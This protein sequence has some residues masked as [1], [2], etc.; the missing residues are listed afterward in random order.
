MRKKLVE[1][2]APPKHRRKG[3]W[4]IVQ[5]TEGIIV[6][7]IFQDGILKSR[8]C[9]DTAG[10]DYATWFPEGKW[11]RRKIEWSYD[12]E[13]EWQCCYYDKSR[14]K[15]FRVSDTDRKLLLD[16]FPCPKAFYDRTDIFGIIGYTEYKW[17]AERREK[18][19]ERR[20]EKVDALMAKMPPLPDGLEDWFYS[21]AVGEEFALK[22]S[23]TGQFVCTVCRNEAPR[24]AYRRDDGGPAKNND[25]AA[26]PQCGSRIR[27]KTRMRNVYADGDFLLMQPVDSTMSVIRLF[28][29]WSRA[30][31]NKKD[32]C[33]HEKARVLAG[34]DKNAV[35]GKNVY[36]WQGYGRFDN[37][38]NPRQ[39]RLSNKQ[40]LYPEGIGQALDGTAAERWSGLLKEFVAAGMKLSYSHLI[41]CRERDALPLMEMLFRG[42]F[43]R[44]LSEESGH[45]WSTG[46]Y[47][48]TLNIKGNSISDV[49]RISE[50]QLINRLRDKNGGGLMLEWLLW[51]ERNKKKLSDRV[52]AWLEENSLRPADMEWIKQRFSPEQAVNYLERQRH[53]QYRGRCIREVIGQ[54]RDY[55]DMCRRLKKDTSDEMVYR[56]R[57]LKRRHD[58]AV[59]ELALR[60][61]EIKA[62]EYSEK[63]PEAEKVLE[64]IAGK[65]E[66]SN[67]K[68]MIVV[69][70]KNIDIVKEGRTL[71]HCAG[72]SDRYFDRIAQHET[73]IC[74]L[75]KTEEPDRPYYTIEVEP[76]GTIRQHRG[77]YDEE[78]EID[79]VKPFLRE[80]QREI[81]KRMS[82][83]DHTLAAASAAKREENIKE[84]KEKNNTRVLEG[85]MEDFMAAEAAG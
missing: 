17:A 21:T 78:P 56:P 19:E 41:T 23:E 61:A 30:A 11:S 13:A 85:L 66:Y 79:E 32:V 52:L 38:S 10:K 15:L 77:M 22:N 76:G 43:Y 6:L 8:H 31:A 45:F 73:Y 65:L 25:M 9:I 70:E 81:R 72:A 28:N 80:W 51:S 49:F 47:Y 68:Y 48:G 75:R 54:Y 36:Y 5:E 63:Y 69:P 40:Y 46:E 64:E 59:E 60:E 2:T 24:E 83:E 37:R 71:H 58:E 57:E 67:G 1:N 33:I 4:T 12:V 35:A 14:A 84:L 18:T 82:R 26:C 16:R 29:G 74:F 3:W 42:R 53:E 62:D 27:F 55:M 20:M 7:N 39:C 34:R 44:L 50:R